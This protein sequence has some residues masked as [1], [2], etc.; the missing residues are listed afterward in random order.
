MMPTVAHCFSSYHV[1]LEGVGFAAALKRVVLNSLVQ[2]VWRHKTFFVHASLD[3]I[4][5]NVAP[6][7]QEDL[8][9]LLARAA[10]HGLLDKRL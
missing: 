5:A 2:L 3:Q 8:R 4:S 9:D 7:L 6:H 1:V 10:E